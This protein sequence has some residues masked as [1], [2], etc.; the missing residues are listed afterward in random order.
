MTIADGHTVSASHLDAA[1][2]IRHHHCIW[3]QLMIR[4]SIWIVAARALI[5]A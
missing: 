1:G 3:S 2:V 5:E 4:R